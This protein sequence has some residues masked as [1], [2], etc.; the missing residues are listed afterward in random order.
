MVRFPPA[1][2]SS[3]F[4]AKRNSL[5]T[6]RPGAQELAA[7]HAGSATGNRYSELEGQGVMARLSE[8]PDTGAGPSELESPHASPK[9]LQT[10]VVS[11]MEIQAGDG[12]GLTMGGDGGKR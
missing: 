8:L 1:L 2:L 6:P 12:L 3:P 5:T 11:G 9:L 4:C 7:E 10:E